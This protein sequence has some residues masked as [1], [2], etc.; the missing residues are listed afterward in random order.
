L[1]RFSA[2]SQHFHSKGS[3]GL[4]QPQPKLAEAHANHL[5]ITSIFMKGQ[6]TAKRALEMAAAGG[7]QPGHRIG[8]DEAT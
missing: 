7:C 2:T 4:T 1:Q 3:Q 8:P 5:P 6:E